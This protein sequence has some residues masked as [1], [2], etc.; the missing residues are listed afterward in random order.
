MGIVFGCSFCM[1]TRC[2]ISII[3]VI[4]FCLLYVCVCLFCCVCLSLLCFVV[5]VANVL[6]VV[7]LVF[8]YRFYVSSCLVLGDFVVSCFRCF[9]L[10]DLFCVYTFVILWLLLLFLCVWVCAC[11]ACFGWGVCLFVLV[12]HLN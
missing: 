12:F 7:G 10:F 2:I 4:V 9:C 1:Y 5:V 6:L 11:L 3:V 8:Q